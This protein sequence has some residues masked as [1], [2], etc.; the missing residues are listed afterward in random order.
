[1]AAHAI[2]MREGK[3]GAFLSQGE[4]GLGGPGGEGGSGLG[5]GQPA[6]STREQSDERKRP[7]KG[8]FL[9]EICLIRG[10][11]GGGQDRL[12]TQEIEDEL[13]RSGFL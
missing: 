6:E 2:I 3:R 9:H 7:K 10:G 4:G 13:W 8:G 11:Q 12:Q 1:M 5:K